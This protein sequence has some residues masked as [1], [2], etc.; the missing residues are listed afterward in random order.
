LVEIDRSIPLRP[1]RRRLAFAT[2][3]S[4][5]GYKWYHHI[6]QPIA[7]L[8]RFPAVA[9]TAWLWSFCLCAL[10]VVAVSG[11]DLLPFA[12]YNFSTIGVGNFNIPP[13][14]GS[15][16]GT[17]YGGQVV[18]RV[19]VKLAQR[20][21]GIYEPE[22]RLYLWPLPALLMPLGLFMYGLSIAKGLSWPIAAVGTGFVGFAIGGMGDIALTY[23]QDAYT[24]ILPD[25]L[26]GVALIRNLLAMMLVFVLS[27]W[28]AGQFGFHR[29]RDKLVQANASRDGNLQCLRFVWMSR[30]CFQPYWYS[31]VYL[32]KEVEDTMRRAIS[33][34]C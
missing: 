29:V 16:L 4:S 17:I 24:E 12:P 14:I 26:V 8:F 19:I 7:L 20:N 5:T 31:N 27:D 34:I 18:D 30:Y 3:N 9:F 32:G 11:S 23:L 22:M 1:L 13:A 25:A 33:S 10:S 15:V 28:F 21:G 2:P 6:T